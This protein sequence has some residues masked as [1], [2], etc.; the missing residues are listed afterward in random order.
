MK[1][2][3]ILKTWEGIFLNSLDNH[4]TLFLRISTK[5]QFMHITL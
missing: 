2:I 5:P 4:D 1:M 3:S